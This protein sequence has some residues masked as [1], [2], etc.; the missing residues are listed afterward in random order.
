MVAASSIVPTLLKKARR[1]AVVFLPDAFLASFRATFR[2]VEWIQR[3]F[4]GTH[5]DADI[6]VI[7]PS[8]GLPTQRNREEY[9]EI[10]WFLM[11]QHL[12]FHIVDTDILEVGRIESGTIQ[13]SDIAAKMVLVPPMPV[14]EEPLQQWL[15]MYE[16]AG[17]VVVYASQASSFQTLRQAILSDMQPELSIIIDGEEA[18][19]VL[20]VKR[21]AAERTLWFLL[22]TGKESVHATFRGGSDLREIPFQHDA[23][24]DFRKNG[25]QYV[26]TLAPFESFVLEAV[27]TV[28]PSEPFARLTVPVTGP[29]ALNPVNTNMLRMDC[30]QM[31]LKNE[32]GEYDAPV[33]VQAVPL[34]NQ[35][36]E[37][38]CRFSPSYQNISGMS[39]NCR[40]R[41]CTSAMSIHSIASIRN[42]YSL[43]WNP[44]QLLAHGQ[45]SVN[46]GNPLQQKR[47]SSDKRSCARKPGG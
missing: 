31:S 18:H 1:A 4:A 46:N 14:I 43:S 26:R 34:M 15:T 17:G 24:G 10:L 39:R 9:T 22:H 40:C 21:T 13:L 8:S 38:K 2:R 32:Q 42:L 35:L 45:L 25:E 16:D 3:L 27:A 41:N 36:I 20:V 44:V 47:L 5:I 11:E 33:A 7:D 23:P 37:G 19:N 6:L 29:A 12:N 30:W 28:E